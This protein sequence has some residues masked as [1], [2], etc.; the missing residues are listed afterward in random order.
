MEEQRDDT[1]R[2]SYTSPISDLEGMSEVLRRTFLRHG[3]VAFSSPV[4]GMDELRHV[5]AALNNARRYA[6][7]QVAQHFQ[8]Q[9]QYCAAN[10][11][12][13]GPK[14]IVPA[15]MGQ[16]ASLDELIRQVKPA[17]RRSLL[18]VAAESSEFAAWLYRDLALPVQATYWRDRALE[19]AQEASD[20]SMQG[21]VL[22]KKSQAAWDER[23]ALHMLT[24]AQAVQE[25]PWNLPLRVQA[26]AVQQEARAL[27]MTGAKPTTIAAKLS[28]ARE[29]LLQESEQ[30]G[31]SAHYNKA[32]F[33]LQ[34]ALSY[35]ESG[36]LDACLD[37][38]DRYLSPENMSHRDYGYFLALQSGAL[39]RSGAPDA[40]A[41]MGIQALSLARET[42][43]ARTGEE[44]YR[45]VK[46]LYRWKDRDSVR[47][48]L[49]HFYG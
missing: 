4:I 46:Q 7:D 19:F 41:H 26:E 34:V 1:N 27:A 9:L 44:V 37:L 18:R 47:E 17:F 8:R 40:A 13:E 10:D 20:F 22:L 42:Y 48:L 35:R 23:D 43:S 29:L 2:I 32:L 36:Q 11:G 45:L 21:Y 24:M 14:S 3:L 5:V 25:G 39:A 6:D 33:S 15:I 12:A 28:Q 49:N 16:I 31:I 38:F 30:S